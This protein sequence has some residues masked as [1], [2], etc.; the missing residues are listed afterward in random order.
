MLRGVV[1]QQQDTWSDEPTH[2]RPD[3][4]WSRT[5]P[6]EVAIRDTGDCGPLGRVMLYPQVLV[7]SEKRQQHFRRKFWSFG[8]LKRCLAFFVS[9]W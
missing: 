8:E 9:S 4:G 5:I 3:D 7:I 6:T 2:F 1:M